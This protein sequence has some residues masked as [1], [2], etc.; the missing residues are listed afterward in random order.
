MSFQ[1][2]NTHLLI[3]KTDL[4]LGALHLFIL[5]MRKRLFLQMFLYFFKNRE[6][7]PE[8]SPC[9]AQLN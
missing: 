1:A 8:R 6:P 4:S 5:I 2:F 3:H 7:Q 9:L